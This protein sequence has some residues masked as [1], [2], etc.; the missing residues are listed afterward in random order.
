MKFRSLTYTLL[1]IITVSS[2]T[3]FCAMALTPV[4]QGAAAPPPPPGAQIAPASPPA[5]NAPPQAGAPPTPNNL[6]PSPAMPPLPPVNPEQLPLPNQPI[7]ASVLSAPG[8]EANLPT[9]INVTG[10]AASVNGQPITYQTLVTKFLAAGAPQFID[11]L[12]NEQLIRQ[13]AKKEGIVINPKDVDAKLTEAKRY[14]LSNAP[15]QSWS[16][17]LATQGRSES[18][19]RDNIYDGLL[20]VKL[21]EKTPQFQTL[22]GKFH[23][24]H[25]LKL[26]TAVPGGPTPV[27]ENSAKQEIVDIRAM[28]VSGKAT[29]EDEARK[30]S[31]DSS[32]A[33]GGD[34]GWVGRDARLDPN[35][36]NAAFSLKEGEISEP[37]KSQYG[38]HLIYLAKIGDHASKAEIAAFLASP[39][40]EDAAR[41]EIQPY[42]K[43]LRASAKIVSYVLQKPTPLKSIP[44][45]AIFSPHPTIKMVP[46]PGQKPATK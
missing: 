43:Q 33:K 28:I 36:A 23:L 29:F 21:V 3:T 11:E 27:S 8:I 20:A 16:Q 9:T 25:I 32:S 46:T 18:Y 41:K 13:T 1:S 35:F 6:K 39:E 44:P 34:L 12:I 2:M 4:P 5:G 37:V 22:D 38:Y 17:F 40:Q 14:L 7:P 10:I 24:Y 15:G 30:E 19:V 42:L 45:S 26:T 31:Q